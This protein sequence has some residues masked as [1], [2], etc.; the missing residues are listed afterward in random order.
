M[1]KLRQNIIEI[2]FEE[3]KAPKL[4]VNRLEEY[5]KYSLQEIANNAN[6]RAP[7]NMPREQQAVF[8]QAVDNYAGNVTDLIERL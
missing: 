1:S 4:M 8:Q 2:C 7:A 6:P 5:F 3:G